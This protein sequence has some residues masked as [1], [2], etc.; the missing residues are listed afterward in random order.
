M[1]F[2]IQ[3]GGGGGTPKRYS[4]RQ[5]TLVAR[6]GLPDLPHARQRKTKATTDH[7]SST[8][9][10]TVVRQP[11]EIVEEEIAEIHQSM[12]E[13]DARWASS[14]PMPLVSKSGEY[15]S[16][17]ENFADLKEAIGLGKPSSQGQVAKAS[18]LG[19]L[20]SVSAQVRAGSKRDREGT[21]DSDDATP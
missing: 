9:P 2:S 11:M 10:M 15:L 16:S 6:P 17:T 1:L 3:N 4:F 5:S 18:H 21:N 12:R 20:R 14:P 13:E 7:P 8:A 19:Q